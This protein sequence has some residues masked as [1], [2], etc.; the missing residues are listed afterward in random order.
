MHLQFTISESDALA[1]SENFYRSSAAHQK[2]RRS[3]RLILPIFLTPV[4]LLFL[5]R[6][7]FSPIPIA[8][9]VVAMISWFMLY[10]LR[11][12]KRVRKHAKKQMGESS[13]AKIFG[14]YELSFDDTYLRSFGPTGE[15]KYN[16]EAVHRVELTDTYLFVF[17]SG[18]MGYP[19]SIG[20]IGFETAQR[21]YNE[22]KR[23]RETTG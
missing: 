11:F 20:Q 15:S 4:M 3:A 19:I 16:W 21:S 23:I 9:F 17:L 8:I 18:P 13:Y 7:G 5:Y 22:I 10:P 12:D 1:F 2:A 14:T 6:F